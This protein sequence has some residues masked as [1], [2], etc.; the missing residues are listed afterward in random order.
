M[1]RIGVPAIIIALVLSAMPSSGATPP[2]KPALKT[3]GA[4]AAVRAQLIV[5]TTLYIGGSFTSVI[6][7]D[8]TSTVSRRHLAAIDL[9]TG[10]LLPWNPATN[11]SVNAI[12]TNG[13]RLLIGGNFTTVDGASRG[14][15]AAFDMNGDLL[16]W[17]TRTD[18][19]VTALHLVGTTLYIGG[20]FTSLGNA[21]RG[22]A[23]ATTLTGDLLP[24]NPRANDRVRAIT[25]VANGDI[26]LG[27]FFTNIGGESIEHIDAVHPLTGDSQ[28]WVYASSQYVYGLVTGPDNNVY[29]AIAG[30]GGKVRSWTSDGNL[31]WTTYT[32]GD[33]NAVTYYNGQ[34][35]AGGHWVYLDGGKYLPRLAAFD[36]SNG[37]PDMSW[38][39]RLNKQVWSFASEGSTMAVGGVFTSVAG[40]TYRRVAVFKT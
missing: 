27:G 40:S 19:D 39:P 38:T 26:V 37:A 30:A 35:I 36:P 4:S 1:G 13:S 34:V 32:D 17:S 20:A 6:S 25:S 3:W 14:H 23:G 9:T 31:R 12:V 18:G 22:N 16:P 7:P 24:W 29:G 28:G 33:V 15:L 21:A 11:G 8:G 10:G 2:A 5:G